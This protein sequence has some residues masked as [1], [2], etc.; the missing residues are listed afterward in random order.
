MR[1]MKTCSHID[2]TNIKIIEV[3]Q[4]F[5]EFFFLTSAKHAFMFKIADSMAVFMQFSLFQSSFWLRKKSYYW[6]ANN[7]IYISLQSEF[8]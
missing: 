7:L 4:R 6:F 2:L 5:T 8:D 3:R 1:Q